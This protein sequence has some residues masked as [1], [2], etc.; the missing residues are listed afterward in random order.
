MLGTVS[1]EDKETKYDR[2]DYSILNTLPL[3]NRAKY[4]V[5]KRHDDV[6]IDY[7]IYI[8]FCRFDH[9]TS[10]LFLNSAIMFFDPGKLVIGS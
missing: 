3:A 7:I 1:V 6:Y 9:V 5:S 10:H 8:L 2:H 4:L